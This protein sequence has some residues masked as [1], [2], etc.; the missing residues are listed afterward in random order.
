MKN[1]KDELIKKYYKELAKQKGAS[2]YTTS[3]DEI[4]RTKEVELILDF[5]SML[6][7]IEKNKNLKVLDLGCGNGYT[8]SLLSKSEPQN[9]YFGLDFSEEL[10]SIAKDRKLPNCECV[11]GDARRVPFE[12]SS[13]DA[14]Y[15]ERTL[16][17]IL[18]WEEQ[19]L[20]LHEIGRVLKPGGYY[21]MIEGFTDGWIN[22]NKAR[23]EC[24][25][26]ELKVSFHNKYFEKKRFFQNIKDIFTVL[27]PSQLGVGWEGLFPTNFL[28]SHYFIS[29]VLHALITKGEHIPN[30]EFVKFF[31]FLPPVGNYSPIQL[32][33]LK[34]KE[35]F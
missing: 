9:I 12:S 1:K 28:S 35:N 13:L 5:F 33:I 2:P 21:L 15:T 34:R 10:I 25:L 17:N 32:Y 23:K 31:S 18:D 3:P 26:P 14:V 27:E 30:T 20:A 19:Q 24:G 11:Q 22:N 16:I 7:T 29:R 4:M 6:K 8:L